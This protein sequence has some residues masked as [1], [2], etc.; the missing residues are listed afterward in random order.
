MQTLVFFNY[1]YHIIQFETEKNH[2]LLN[3]QIH[4]RV[5]MLMLNDADSDIEVKVVTWR[6]RCCSHGKLSSGT[7]PCWTCFSAVSVGEGWVGPCTESPGSGHGTSRQSSP[8]L[9]PCWSGSGGRSD[10]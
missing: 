4:V 7:C 2:R 9:D 6:W 8:D 10:L 1:M 3:I 5:I